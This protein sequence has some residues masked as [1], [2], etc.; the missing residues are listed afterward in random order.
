MQDNKF[1]NKIIWIT[2][3]SRGIGD[4]IAEKLF[5]SGATLVLSA[6]SSTSFKKISS[7]LA[8]YKNV[9]L[10]PFDVSS[11]EEVFNA[12]G[13]IKAAVGDPDVLINNAGIAKFKPFADF[14]I[15]DFERVIDVNFKGYFYCAKA[16]IGEMLRRKTGL[17]L[18]ISSNAALKVFTGSSIYS[19]S[20]SAGLMMSRVL[21]EEVR[22]SGVKVVDVLPG[23]TA[24][25]IWNEK[26]LAENRHKMME[27]ADV[28]QVVCDAIELSL[29]DRMM[30]EEIL[31][32]PQGGDLK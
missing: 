14:D 18:N 12:Y 29:N 10:F 31:V 11:R 32:R 2:G 19:A 13:K 28:A 16:V 22:G 27:A 23:A 30:V 24:T 1:A 9:F 26:A 5:D 4:A 6:S 20:K 15:A 7:K 21:R 3:A 17:I 8:E 25:E